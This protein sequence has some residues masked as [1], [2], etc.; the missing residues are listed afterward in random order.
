ME[1][2]GEGGHWVKSLVVEPVAKELVRK[3]VL[4]AYSVGIARP[5]IVRDPVARGG[6]IKGGQIA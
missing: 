2:G 5:E 4:T 1:V 6:R 3:G